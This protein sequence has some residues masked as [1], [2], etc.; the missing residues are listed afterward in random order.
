[1]QSSPASNIKACSSN[2]RCSSTTSKIPL[3]CDL[4]KE[5][6]ELCFIECF[7]PARHFQKV[8][9]RIK[10]YLVECMCMVCSQIFLSHTKMDNHAINFFSSCNK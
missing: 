6:Y 7:F 4:L 9:K 8:H 2:K 1:M 3:N 5:N 10:K